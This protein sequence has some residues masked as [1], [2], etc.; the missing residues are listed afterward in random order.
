MD[1]VLDKLEEEDFYYPK[2]EPV[3]SMNSFVQVCGRMELTKTDN[4]RFQLNWLTKT[5]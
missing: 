4:T 5:P 1:T 2:Q 3:K